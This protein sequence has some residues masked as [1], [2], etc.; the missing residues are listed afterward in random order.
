MLLNKQTFNSHLSFTQVIE[1]YNLRLKQEDGCKHEMKEQIWL[2]RS[3]HS[4]NIQ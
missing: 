3:Q 2:H 1:A 4:N